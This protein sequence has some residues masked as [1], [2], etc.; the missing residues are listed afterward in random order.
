MVPT[1]TVS[2]ASTVITFRNT[3][4]TIALAG[5]VKP[6]TVS[7]VC[8]SQRITAVFVTNLVDAFKREPSVAAVDPLNFLRVTSPVL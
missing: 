7:E 1:S 2:V 8:A 3:S 6:V 5:S 4:F